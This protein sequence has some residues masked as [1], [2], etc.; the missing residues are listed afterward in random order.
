MTNLPPIN[1]VLIVKTSSLGD[2]ICSLPVLSQLRRL[3]PSAHIGWVVD[4]RFAD[5]LAAE[6]RLDELYVF[7]RHKH[8][9]RR[10]IREAVGFVREIARLGRRLRQRSWDVAIDLQNLLKSSLILWSSRARLRIAEY[11]KIRHFF[12]LLA[13]NK[14]IR[15][16][17]RHA[18]LRYLELAA[19]IGV[20]T[21]HVEFGLKP[22]AAACRW[23]DDRVRRLPGPRVAVNVGSARP[24]KTWPPERFAAALRAARRSQRFSVVITGSSSER[25]W[26]DQ[27]ASSIDA[28]V[29]NL[30]GQTSLQQLV[31]AL[32][33]C[34]ILLTADSG[35]MHIMAALGRPTVALF[36]PTDP[37][38]NGPWGEQHFIVRSPTGRMDDL[39][40]APVA[41][42]V[43]AALSTQRRAPG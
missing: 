35:P 40:P 17:A 30:A 39:D 32:D 7:D 22:S 15:P 42:A 9:H 37:A 43:A 36:G 5:I 12:S 21:D 34:D 24:E 23:A 31:A 10:A 28:P 29:A 27:I 33:A 26:A 6:D 16:R 38:Q 20:T 13:A 14:I 1:S 4:V 25:P 18:V 11:E 41:D 19:P 3:Y 8:G 2:I